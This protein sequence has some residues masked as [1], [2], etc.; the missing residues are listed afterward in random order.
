MTGVLD[1]GGILP[2]TGP[3]PITA[4][5]YRHPA[6]AGRAV[7]RLVG[8]TVGP[9]ED[10]AMEFLGFAA[11]G[12]AEV[13]HGRPGTL[14]FP[15]WALVHDPDHGRDALALVK[16]MERLARTARHKPGNAKDGYTALAARLGDAAPRLL[17][18][19]WEQAGR[20]FLD[21]GNQRMAGTC[22]AEAR[23]A[24]QV[25]GLTVDEDRVRAVHL[26]FA[27]AGGLTAAMLSAYA[28]GVAERR[29]APEA[30]QLVRS[31]SR[32]R[33]AGGQAP[34]AGLVTDLARLA[35]AAGLNADRETDDV[36]TRL[37]G[38]PAM[39]RSHPGVWKSLRKSLIRLG[40]RDPAVRARLLEIMPSP[41]GW[42]TDIREQWLELLEAT[43][44]AADLAAPTGPASRWLARFLD[45][46]RHVY[47]HTR[48]NARLLALVERMVPR[49]IAEGG[50]TLADRPWDADLDVL[51]LCR[52]AGVPV[53]I[54]DGHPANGFEVEQWAAD[55]GAGR[56]DLAAIAADPALRPRL[57]RGV[58]E[59]LDRF[60]DRQPVG[61]A[62][63][64][65][66]LVAR[67]DAAGV[68]DVLV[69]LV[70]TLT[71]QS[72]GSTVAGVEAD[73]A[74][75]SPLWSAAGLATAPAAFA[76]LTAVDLPAVLARTLR[77]GLV[78][79]L[80]WPA[81][82]AAA[83]R[84]D[85][86][87]VG[88]S[89]PELVLHDERT[90]LVISPDG[91]VTEHGFRFPATGEAHAPRDWAPEI[92]CLLVDGDLLVHW[93]SPG[94]RAGYWSSRPHEVIEGDW[95]VDPAQGWLT[96]ALPVPGGGLTTGL[97]AVHPG[98]ARAVSPDRWPLAGDGVTFWRYQ[99]ANP[100]AAWPAQHGHRWQ[101]FDPRTGRGG[102]VSRPAFFAAAGDDLV[103]AE[104]TL[105]PVPFAESPLGVRD[106]LAGWRVS[107]TADGAMTGT[108]ID[109]RSVPGPRGPHRRFDEAPVA[110][111]SLPG[112][113]EP[114]PVS[115]GG[116]GVRV[117]TAD[118]RHPLGEHEAGSRTVPPLAWWHALRA[119]DEAGSAALRVL[120][121]ET[122][123]ALLDVRGMV[124]AHVAECL[125]A[126]T[127]AVLR[128]RIID[129]VKRAIQVRSRLAQVPAHLSGAAVWAAAFA[130][131][132]VESGDAGPAEVASGPASATGAGVVDELVVG[133]G[134]LLGDTERAQDVLRAVASPAEG[135]WLST[136]G[137]SEPNGM[138]E[139]RNRA[140]HGTPFTAEWLRTAAVALPWL[141]YRLSWDDPRRAALPGALRLVRERLRNPDLLV[142]GA[143]TGWR[144]GRKPGRRSSTGRP[145]ARTWRTTSR[146]RI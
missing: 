74:V 51:D 4:R 142:G 1:A 39:A 136:D 49:L 87:E 102:R 33:V 144:A 146:R 14:V 92:R 115:R 129:L 112:A 20:A 23:R 25:H 58:R 103:P 67:F 66:L 55:A 65:V 35:R 69:E 84:L 43:G 72:A 100:G 83:A 130:E 46:H 30:Y 94:G 79:E 57:L 48:R 106:G 123:A 109:G 126:V 54:G 97:R 89:W 40:K 61:R 47:R 8:A 13:G 120:D 52:A 107:R 135:D 42:D 9:A 116:R 32:Q 145:T 70:G 12:S 16:D 127:D 85:R 114:L 121:E 36:V 62:M 124:G 41:P 91:H 131:A 22:F 140:G 44:A 111:V 93:R 10:L 143:C 82:E 80:S 81:Y 21:V 71:A 5:V 141:A 134:R 68:R 78:A 86:I 50:V 63:P 101:E 137:R 28:R 31:L 73:L 56:R 64:E 45:L 122:A 2:G 104:A 75:L 125:P 133:L 110:A 60:R 18:T 139:I 105:R 6:L 37:L 53:D 24:E 90:A 7:V 38:Y 117:W 15:A 132:R 88:V 59:M 95:R 118:G 119:R 27:L 96:P 138:F 99:P 17:P 128:E 3:H 108:G 29:P 26:E 77:A 76:R 11:A 98:D 19:F 34:H 113:G